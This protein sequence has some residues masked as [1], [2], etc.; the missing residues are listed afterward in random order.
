M[1]K[2]ALCCKCGIRKTKAQFV[3]ITFRGVKMNGHKRGDIC[4]SCFKKH[5]IA[6]LKELIN[7]GYFKISRGQVTVHWPKLMPI[8][9]DEDRGPE[10]NPGGVDPWHSILF[11]LVKLNV[12]S[13]RP[14]GNY[15]IEADNEEFFLSRFLNKNLYFIDRRTAEDFV[16]AYLDYYGTK[17]HCGIRQR[18][19][20]VTAN[21]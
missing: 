17:E 6:S 21:K 15:I 8:H 12:L 11:M 13:K 7:A 14:D 18:H 3:T 5:I 10:K 20:C 9:A 19:F 2:Y 4:Y 1:A 16:E